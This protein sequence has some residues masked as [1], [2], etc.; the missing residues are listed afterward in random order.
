MNSPQDKIAYQIKR[1]RRSTADVI[2]ERDGSVLVRAPE[3]LPDERIEDLVESK[4]YW[5]YKN[6][7][8][9]LW[10]ISLTVILFWQ[11]I[12]CVELI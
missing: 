2:V 3:S 4:R 9:N 5:I 7:A 8:E 12:I 6:L 10:L 1:S 11:S